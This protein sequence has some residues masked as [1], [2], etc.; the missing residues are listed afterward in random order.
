MRV[1]LIFGTVH[2]SYL[3]VGMENLE[4]TIVYYVNKRF[5]LYKSVV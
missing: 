5:I 4:F 3:R 2:Y 1:F